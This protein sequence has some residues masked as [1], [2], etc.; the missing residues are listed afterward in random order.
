[1]ESIA[2]V[3]GVIAYMGTTSD[4]LRKYPAINGT[5]FVNATGLFCT[6]GFIDSHVHL[7]TAGDL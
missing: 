3:K 2:I 6:P 4:V 5:I 7:L 1:M